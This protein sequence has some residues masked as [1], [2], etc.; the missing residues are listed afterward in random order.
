MLTFIPLTALI[1]WPF[2]SKELAVLWQFMNGVAKDTKQVIDTHIRVDEAIDE[3][4]KVVVADTDSAA[5]T[6]IHHVKKLNHTATQLVKY[7]GSSN[8][9][10]QNMDDEI[11]ASVA[12]IHKISDFVNQLPKMIRE[13]V[14]G[15]QKTAIKEIGSLG[16]F[17]K[18]IKEISLQ[19]N[20]LA[21]NAAIEAAHAGES[22][23]GFAVVAGEVRKL[24]IRAA[25]AASMIENGLN[26]AKRSLQEGLGESPIEQQILDAS[27]VVSSIR[28]LQEVYEDIR[29]YYKTLFMVVT[30]HNNN[31]SKEIAE[32]LGQIQFQD[33]MRQRIERATEAI[34]K[35]N[36][37]LVELSQNLVHSPSDLGEL[38]S[39]MQE[40]L[41]EYLAQ[42][43]CHAPVDESGAGDGDGDGLPKIQLF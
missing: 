31:L 32:M 12:S 24:S 1:A 40:V 9:S 34:N 7:L 38:P 43:R 39:K 5:M 26:G 33:I 27:T 22:G 36:Q 42:E 35:R 17:I 41:E 23:R 37:V 2:A 30:D 11:D 20:L 21:L 8:L 6:L 15:I 13:D 29:Q 10:A 14:I 25:E 16:S 4:L 18:I 19:T 28:R 3:Q